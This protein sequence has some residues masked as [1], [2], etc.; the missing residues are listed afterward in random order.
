MTAP[1]L[2][3]QHGVLLLLDGVEGNFQASPGGPPP[4]A[5]PRPR[6]RLRPSQAPPTSTAPA[7]RGAAAAY[8]LAGPAPQGSARFCVPPLHCPAH[9]EGLASSLGPA[10]S[11]PRPAQA[12]H[13]P[14]PRPSKR[15]RPPGPRPTRSRWR[16]SAASS[17]PRARSA[18]SAPPRA[19]PHTQGPRRLAPPT[20]Q[21]CGG[22]QMR[23]RG[24]PLIHTQPA[25]RGAH[26]PDE[27][28]APHP[29]SALA[30]VR[31][32][33]R[34]SL[35]ASSPR[36]SSPAPASQPSVAVVL[37]QLQ[38]AAPA[39]RP[40]PGSA[41]G[42]RR[43]RVTVGRARSALEPRAPPGARAGGGGRGPALSPPAA[44]GTVAQAASDGKDR[45]P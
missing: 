11:R 19:P 45:V 25:P 9:P 13:F 28:R 18:R 17:S 35:S 22:N 43:A 36:T 2:L 41:R 40:W 12:P 42:R 10:L 3:L 5:G 34:L 44:G 20:L 4:P 24:R 33:A 14:L 16:C 29:R 6:C 23:G 26:T 8:R 37:L 32:A 39:P 38:E 27:G 7:H 30:Q 1:P 31:R 15:S 21:S